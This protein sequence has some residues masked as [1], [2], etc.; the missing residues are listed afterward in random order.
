MVCWSYLADKANHPASWG[1]FKQTMIS[2][3][4]CNENNITY[5]NHSKSPG[6]FEKSQVFWSPN[7][8]LLSHI[9]PDLNKIHIHHPSDRLEVG[10][11][12]R[13]ARKRRNWRNFAI[14]V[15]FRVPCARCLPWRDPNPGCIFSHHQDGITFLGLGIPISC[16]P[17]TVIAWKGKS[18]VYTLSY[19]LVWSQMRH[20]FSHSLFWDQTNEPSPPWES[21]WCHCEKVMKTAFCLREIQSFLFQ[22]KFMKHETLWH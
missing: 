21:I 15:G 7:C 5:Q 11:I 8:F 2:N 10:W 4:V 19:P 20:F 17:S 14:F 6:V 16:K 13:S 3:E 9:F 12:E 18:K 22:N 1:L